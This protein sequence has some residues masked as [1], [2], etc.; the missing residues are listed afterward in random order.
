MRDARAADVQATA[1]ADAETTAPPVPVHGH[2]DASRN[3]DS[4]VRERVHARAAAA[5]RA[6]TDAVRPASALATRYA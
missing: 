2:G 4:A 6:P 3:V 5:D 1:P